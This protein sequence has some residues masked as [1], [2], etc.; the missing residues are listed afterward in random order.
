MTIII[1]DD[2]IDILMDGY[3]IVERTIHDEETV[4]KIKELL[5]EEL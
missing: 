4:T 5:K 2:A 3:N 1:R